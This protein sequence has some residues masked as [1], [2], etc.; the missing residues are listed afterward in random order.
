[1]LPYVDLVDALAA[2]QLG[3][4]VL[5]L[6][7]VQYN[8]DLLSSRILFACCAA[9]VLHNLFTVARLGTGFMSYLHALVATM[10][11]KTA[12]IKEP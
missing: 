11:R 6:E 5:T 9:D 8:H 7:T 10:I 12:L 2:T 1:M 3:N 4:A